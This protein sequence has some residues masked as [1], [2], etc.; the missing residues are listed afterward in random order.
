MNRRGRKKTP[1]WAN[2]SIANYLKTDSK[3]MVTRIL[4]T[5][6]ENAVNHADHLKWS[7]YLEL[8]APFDRSNGS[9][10]NYISANLGRFVI[11]QVLTS[12]RESKKNP[13]FLFPLCC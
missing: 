10:Q 5:L 6:I 11:L 8:L 12:E 1:L 2:Y 13:I 4:D 9:H 3:A 7:E